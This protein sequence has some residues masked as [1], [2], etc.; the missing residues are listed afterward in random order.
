MGPTGGWGWTDYL[1]VSGSMVGARFLHGDGSVSFRYFHQDNLG[2]IAVLTDET[3]HVVERD[4]YDPWGKRRFLN[5]QDDP[6]GSLANL[7]QTSRG[8]T[9][10]EMLASVGLVHLNGRVYDP[11]VGRMLSADPV[12]GDPLNGQTWN[13]YSYVG[14]NPLA[15]T[16]PTGYCAVC[17]GE[18][19]SRVSNGISGFLQRNPLV[20]AALQIAAVALCR[21][22]LQCAGVAAT[23][24]SFVVTGLTTGRLD[25]ALLSAAISA[26]TAAAFYAVGDLTGNFS[27][28]LDPALGGHGPL[29]FG[30]DAYMVNVVGHALVGC[31]VAA[32]SGGQCGAGALSALV[33]AAAGPVVAKLKFETGLVVTSTLGGFASLA[34]GG[35]FANGAVTGAF[36]YLFNAC[37]GP[38]GCFKAGVAIGAAVGADSAIVLTA[39]TLGAGAPAGVAIFAIDTLIGGTI[40]AISDIIGDAWTGSVYNS[41]SASRPVPGTRPG[42]LPATGQEPNSTQ[43]KDNGEGQG[44]IRDYGPDGRAIKDFDFGHNH[45]PDYPGDPHAHDWDWSQ[46]PPRGPGRPIGPNE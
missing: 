23:V 15:F 31:G 7:S 20:G 17:F 32:A 4:S 18:F 35:K 29:A 11:Y 43:V 2:S 28:V 33:P 3:G 45:R 36:G 9:G 27:G 1:M 44:Q 41:E 39:G 42:D 10:Q 22:D 6:T 14:N 16:D 46:T 34:G 26:Y 37:G 21:G 13:R 40:G 25:S 19:F 38:N 8:F 5:G 30:S 12:V 24:S